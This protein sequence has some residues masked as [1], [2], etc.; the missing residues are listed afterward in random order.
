M[1]R[2]APVPASHRRLHALEEENCGACAGSGYQERELAMG[3]TYRVRGHGHSR[4]SARVLAARPSH[5]LWCLNPG[6]Q[7]NLR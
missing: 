5:T 4:D 7:R 6:R 1:E 2:A 3:P